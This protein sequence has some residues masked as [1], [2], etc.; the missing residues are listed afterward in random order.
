MQVN[1]YPQEQKQALVAFGANLPIEERSPKETVLAAISALEDRVGAP[2]QPSRVWQTPAFPE[3]A[4]P[5]FVN[6]AVAFNWSGSAANLLTILHDVEAS[7]GRRRTTRWEARKMDLD[8]IALGDLICPD[9]DG[10]SRWQE[11]SPE[12]AATQ[13]PGQ[14]I[15]PHPRLSER[16]FVLV[17][18][19]EIAEGW[20]HP[21]LGHTVA[22][23]LVA[24]PDSA[25]DGMSPLEEPA[26]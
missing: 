2:V 16:A 7:F 19:A 12:D 13:T 11:M 5:P 20:C 10:F 8:L 23:M 6:A 1:K 25:F 26:I 15:L 18:L 9:V 17:P 22:E 24:L 21:V 3:G 4:G 14:L